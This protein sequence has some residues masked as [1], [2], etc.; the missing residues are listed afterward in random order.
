MVTYTLTAPPLE[1]GR[2]TAF[3]TTVASVEFSVDTTGCGVP[4][5]HIVRKASGAAGT[6]VTFNE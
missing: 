3:D 2:M 6:T 1:V 4:V 5:G